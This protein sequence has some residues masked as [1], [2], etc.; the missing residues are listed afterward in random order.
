MEPQ[1]IEKESFNIIGFEL[2]TSVKDGRNFREIPA[3]WGD[4]MKAGGQDRIP[5][6]IDP[7]ELLGICMDMEKDGSFSYLIAARVAGVDDVP[8]GMVAKTVPA[9]RYAMFTARGPMPASIQ[10]MVTYIHREWFPKSGYQYGE[11]AEFELYDGRCEKG[12]DAEVDIYVP[13]M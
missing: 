4:V 7:G 13:V 5:N 10:K 1:I 6:R 2:R 3:F 11:G 8:E 9:A 12:D